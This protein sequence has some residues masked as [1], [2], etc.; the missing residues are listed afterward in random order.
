MHVHTHT[1]TSVRARCESPGTQSL[2]QRSGSPS[3]R[4][5]H[6]VPQT[7]F[8]V[9]KGHANSHHIQPPAASRRGPPHTPRRGAES[10]RAAGERTP[11]HPPRPGWSA[12]RPGGRVPAA[13]LSTPGEKRVPRH[14]WPDVPCDARVLPE[15]PPWAGSHLCPEGPSARERL[16]LPG[17]S[18]PWPPPRGPGGCTCSNWRTL[19]GCQL[20]NPARLGTRGCP[21]SSVRHER[22]GVTGAAPAQQP[23]SPP[24]PACMDHCQQQAQ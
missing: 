13:R 10:R 22:Q 9:R 5:P 11:P 3:L 18:W 12:P 19:T 20:R 23:H 15:C 17:A 2:H 7:A 8:G 6:L 16:R 24:G 4:F 1:H 14:S 21:S